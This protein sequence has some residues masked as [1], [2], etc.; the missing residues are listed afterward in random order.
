MPS[1]PLHWWIAAAVLVALELGSGSFYLL[2]LAVGAAA[3]ALAA[4]LGL[5]PALQWSAAALVGL[6]AVAALY[7]LRRRQ[8]RRSTQTNRDLNLDIGSVLEVERWD[9]NGNS[10]VRWRG[11]DWQARL[12]RGRALPGRFRIA[13]VD[14][15]TLVLDALDQT[16]S[17]HS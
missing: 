12:G 17:P 1:T 16:P 15:N 10:R 5:E 6:G 7:L 3:A 14:A 8:P 2:M 11:T 4:H 9:D 13:A